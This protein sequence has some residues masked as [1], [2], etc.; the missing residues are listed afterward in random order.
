MAE[1]SLLEAFDR[2]SLLASD[3]DNTV[4]LTSEPL[5]GGKTVEEAY[6]TAIYQVLGRDALGRYLK[7]G[8]LRNRAPGEIVAELSPNLSVQLR[9]QRTEDLVEAKMAILLPQF[10]QHLPDGR[11]W[12]ST[13]DGMPEVWSLLSGASGVSTAIITSGHSAAIDRFFDVHELPQPDIAVTDDDMRPLTEILPGS[14]FVKPSR[15]LIDWVHQ[16]WL[17]RF[18][19]GSLVNQDAESYWWSRERI[20]YVGDDIKKD[21]QMAKNAGVE[22][23]HVPSDNS[24]QAWQNI[25]HLLVPEAFEG[26]G[27]V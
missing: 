22:F 3:F 9:P 1:P 20:T 12:P 18:E 23:V 16:Q 7:S 25:G 10:G 14:M 26:A 4:A 17:E 2:E 8:G 5:P 27:R 15:L 11:L 6:E 13:V 24:N 19:L 21:G